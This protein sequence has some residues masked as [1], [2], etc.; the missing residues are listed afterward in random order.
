MEK[1]KR[2]ESLDAVCGL[3][4]VYMIYGHICLWSGIQQIEWIPRLLYFFMPWFFFK[5]GLFFKPR[6]LSE[7]LVGGARRLLLPYVAFSILGQ[8]VFYVK[9]LCDGNMPWQN[10]ILS[11]LRTLLHEGAVLGNSPLWFLLT[12]FLVRVIFDACF[13]KGRECAG[14]L[15]IVA[16][17]VAYIFRLMDFHTFFY[18]PNVCAGVFFYGC[19]Y[20]LREKVNRGYVIAIATLLYVLYAV[21]F[22]SYYDFRSNGIAVEAYP[23]CIIASV[24][25]IISL[26]WIFKQVSILQK[27]FVEIGKNSMTYYAV[28]WL[29][30]GA[31]SLLFQNIL[32]L[33]NYS[34]FAA[35]VMANVVTLPYLDKQL[36][37]HCRWIIGK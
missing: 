12:L 2:D 25:G 8:L 37:R 17:I 13:L 11:P 35:F 24:G 23:F 21:W 31:S 6:S 30:L 20:F 16:I 36:N 34:L 27:P 26:D 9:W 22:P 15:S 5:S 29:V 28:H 7:E 1:K 3:M 4:I 10:Y 33:A 14:V 18:L 32:N 19:G